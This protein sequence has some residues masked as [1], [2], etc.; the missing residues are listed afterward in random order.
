MFDSLVE[1]AYSVA[2]ML[3]MFKVT[4]IHKVISFSYFYQ[5]WQ[6]MNILTIFL[7]SVGARIVFILAS[8]G[9]V[10]GD[11]EVVDWEEILSEHSKTDEYNRVR[12]E[13]TN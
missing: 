4:Q 12:I 11:L 2:S 6:L 7:I 3:L 9:E 10:I 8:D 13:I 1:V 5:F